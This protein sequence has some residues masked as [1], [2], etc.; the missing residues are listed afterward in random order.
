MKH[1]TFPKLY[2]QSLTE[3]HVGCEAPRAYFIPYPSDAIAARDNRAESDRFRSLCGDWDFHYYA[4]P[5]DLPDFTVEGFSTEGFDKLTVPRSWQTVLDKGYDTPNYTNHAY[6]FPVD[7]PNVPNDNPCGLYVRSFAFDKVA[8]AGKKIYINFEGVDSCFYLYVNDKFVAYS[9]VSHMTSEI[10]VT[11]VLVG[12]ENTLKVLV[13]KWCDG[14]YLEDQDKFRFS[15]IFREVYLLVR[16]EIHIRD[17]QVYTYLNDTLEKATA[18]VKLSL[19]G[20]AAVS[21]RLLNPAGAFVGGGEVTLSGDG[22]C[23]LLVDHVLLWSDETPNLYTLCI[24][25]GS[26]YIRI[27]VGFRSVVIRDRV[28]YINGKK[29]KAKGVNRHDS[30]PLLGSA[31]PMEHMMKDLMLLKRHNVNMIRTSHYPNDPR[32]PGLCDKYGFYL[33]DETDLEAHGMQANNYWDELSDGKDWEAAYLDRVTRMYER[34]KNH[35]CVIMWSLGNESGVGHNQVVMADYLHARD[36]RNLVH[37]EDISRRRYNLWRK[38]PEDPH[39][40]DGFYDAHEDIE[41]R[42]Y[43]SLASIKEYYLDNPKA[44]RPFFLCEYSHAMGN[45]PGDLADYWELIYENDCFF[46]GCVWEMLDHSVATG[47]NRLADPHYIYGGDFGDKPNDSNF[48]VDGLVYP[49]RRPHTGMLELKEVLKPY[50]VS[51]NARTSTLTI[52]NLRRFADLSDLDF[53]YTVEHNGKRVKASRISAPSIAAESCAEFVLNLGVIP[54]GYNVLN[55]S[56]VQNDVTDWADVGYEVGFDQTELSADVLANAAVLPVY[57]AFTVETDDYEIRVSAS[58]RVYTF[59]TFHGTVSSILSSGRELLTSPIVPTIWRAPTDNDRRIKANWSKFGYDNAMLY[60]ASCAL[61]EQTADSVSVKA[62]LSMSYYKNRPVLWMDVTY[63]VTSDGMLSLEYAVKRS[64]MPE[65][66]PLPR[67][68]ITFSMPEET[69]RLEYF[70]RGP[71]ESYIDKRLASRLGHFETT[72]SEHFEHY[73]RPQENMAHADTKWMQVSSIAGNG[74]YALRDSMD[75]SFNCSHFTQKQLTETM[76]DYELVPLKDTVVHIDYRHAGIGSNS[77]GPELLEK[78]RLAEKEF[79]FRVK[80]LPA[81]V[82]D[83]DPFTLV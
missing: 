80:L 21:Y 47:D 51:F 23:E 56:A 22:E 18:N 53:V 30:H 48:C 57:P 34:D 63:T 28:I 75:F 45:G 8:N 10:D 3:L 55:V 14:S 33:C 37:C 73:V 16:D 82:N 64:D 1:F 76:H 77:C 6:P 52:K 67:F 60:C 46:G 68:G 29:V 42:M 24:S 27:P 9:Q 78:Y 5:K 81:L 69:E 26:E 15:G 2:H 19:T 49:D 44:V 41:S 4:S 31:T 17:L 25:C 39:A 7:P 20:S 54:S 74:I 66:P 11:D 13:L 79:T 65:L 43:P 62:T 59:D 58:D 71:V 61:S 32:L 12:G 83:I 38:L 35:P 50:R 72:V 36:P 70:G 40:L